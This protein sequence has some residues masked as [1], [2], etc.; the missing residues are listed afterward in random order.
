MKPVS[1][2]A[3]ISIFTLGITFASNASEFRPLFD[4]KSLEGWK[5]P[6]MSYWSVQDGT[7]TAECTDT[8]PAKKNQ[9]LVWQH[10]EIDDFVLRLKF[11]IEGPP[12]AN[13]GIQIRSEIKEDGHAIGYQADIDKQGTWLGAIY[14]EHTQ[15]KMLAKRG[16][17]TEI[18]DQGDRKETQ[19]ADTNKLFGDV[20]TT[21][22]NEY[23]I[24]ARG[25]HIQIHVNGKLFS[26]VI[27]HQSSEREYSGK[28]ALQLHSGP[29]V[30]VQF[31]DIELKRLPLAEGRKKIV[32]LAGKPSHRPG[33]HEHNAGSWLLT[34][35]IND[36][37][38]ELAQANVYYN[39]G[40]PADSTAFDNADAI[41]IY[42][43]G[44]GR[45]L[46]IPKMEEIKAMM[47]DGI[48]LGCLHY[49]VEVPK[50]EPGDDFLEMIGGYFETY[51][52]VNP[53]WDADFKKLPNHAITRGVKPYKIR[54]EWYYHMRFR[55]EMKG[56]TPILSALPPEETRT[57]RWGHHH[58][59]NPF[60]AKNKG[61]EEVVMWASENDNGSRGFG[62][63]GGHFHN[64]W[65]NEDQRKVVLNAA[66]WVAGAEV[67][68][69]GV[70]SS[71][72]PEDLTVRLDDKTKK[73]K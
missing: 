69:N 55:P 2:R 71:I 15:R 56:V 46:A 22:W 72:S 33:D 6:N 24:T 39:N 52:S 53:H 4:G 65:A 66:L 10:G 32:F 57:S 48:G 49:G 67:P 73:K 58:G 26:E 16:Q 13:S 28:L 64:N 29:P 40:W 14:D 20:N 38:S 1:V 63:T 68:K 37:A 35:C 8:N 18:N 9:F 19:F 3:L 50:G 36:S 30:K 27:D 61:N 17:R 47:A 43:D 70:E 31:K 42:C 21:E 7:I 34:K 54:D 12:N 25:S 45:H 51:Y 5:S 62:F 59:G 11:R 23:Q 44:G 41:I 60:V